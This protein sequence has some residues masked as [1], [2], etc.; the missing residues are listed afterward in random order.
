MIS[1]DCCQAPSFAFANFDPNFVVILNLRLLT[2]SH[3]KI[4]AIFRIRLIQNFLNRIIPS[5]V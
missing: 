1:L 3:L 2:G 5:Y 4:S